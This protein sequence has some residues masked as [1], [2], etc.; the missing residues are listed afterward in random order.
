M[1]VATPSLL[2][3]QRAAHLRS[4]RRAFERSSAALHARRA[5]HAPKALYTQ[6]CCFELLLRS[7]YS[8]RRRVT[9][10]QR[11][12]KGAAANS[13]GHRPGFFVVVGFLAL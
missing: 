11:R 1:S 6:L 5:L 4:T 9:N 10:T 7:A 13:P 8:L 12:P 2:S 3:Q